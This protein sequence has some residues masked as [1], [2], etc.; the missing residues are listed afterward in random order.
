[1][2]SKD[3]VVSQTTLPETPGDTVPAPV[4][5]TVTLYVILSKST[6]TVWSA[7][8]EEMYAHRVSLML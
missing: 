7:S 6:A 1:M 5:L 8:T 3:K 2:I 4:V